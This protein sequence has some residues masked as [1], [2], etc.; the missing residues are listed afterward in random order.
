MIEILNCTKRYRKKVALDS[1]SFTFEQGVY[2]ILGPNGAGKTTLIKCICGLLRPN[3]GD[4]HISGSGIGYLPQQFGAFQELTVKQMME[5]FAVLKELEKAR[6][7]DEISLSLEQVNLTDQANEK[8]SHL[9][10]GMVRRLGIAQ[11]LLGNPEII[12][13]DEPTVGLDPEERIRVIDVIA[14]IKSRKTILVSTHIVEDVES[15]CE[16]AVIMRE[17]RIIHTSKSSALADFAKGKAFLVD[18]RYKNEVSKTGYVKNTCVKGEKTYLYVLS[19][20]SQPGEKIQPTF[21]DGY[22]CVIKDL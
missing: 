6:I 17:G 2:G 9:S 18:E 19:S 20:E 3:S 13:L 5:Y 22:L 11:A 14:K 8:I 10:G 15:L 12:L 16:E 4:L 21:E 1:I 7:S